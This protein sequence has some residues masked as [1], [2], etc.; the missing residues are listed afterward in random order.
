MELVGKIYTSKI[1]HGTPK[2]VFRRCF[3]FSKCAISNVQGSVFE[4]TM[5]GAIYVCFF[6][7]HFGSAN[8][9]LLV[10]VGG[11]DSCDPRYERD[12]HLK[13]PLESQTTNP[14]QPLTISWFGGSK[15]TTI[16]AGVDRNERE[17]EN[18]TQSKTKWWF[19]RLFIF[20]PYLRKWSN[21][22]D[23]QYFWL[24][25]NHQQDKIFLDLVLVELVATKLPTED[26]VC[27]CVSREISPLH[28]AKLSH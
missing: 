28:A 12:C 3:S 26:P 5:K 17:I 21:L 9:Y 19:Q 25:W 24:A 10:W 11:L 16:L 15:L 13:A 7:C 22:T 18:F 27:L 20:N 23:I 2:L 4:G 6:S 1:I 14:N 8:G